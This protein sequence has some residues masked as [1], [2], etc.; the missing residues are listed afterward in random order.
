M[1]R[2]VTEKTISQVI[3]ETKQHGDVI[4][5]IVLPLEQVVTTLAGGTRETLDEVLSWG[6]FGEKSS[7]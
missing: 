6:D 7:K 4:A 1:S 5:N 3:I 2:T